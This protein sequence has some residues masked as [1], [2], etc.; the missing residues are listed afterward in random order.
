MP[1]RSRN[2]LFTAACGIV[3]VLIGIFTNVIAVVAGLLLL[4]AAGVGIGIERRQ[5]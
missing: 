4:L 1:S 3:L 2:Y 5:G